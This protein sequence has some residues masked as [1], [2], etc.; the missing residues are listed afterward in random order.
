MAATTGE[1]RNE[2]QKNEPKDRCFLSAARPI[3]HEMR[4]QIIKKRRIPPRIKRLA[5]A[6]EAVESH[7]ILEGVL[8][9][10]YSRCLTASLFHGKNASIPIAAKMTM[11]T[12]AA[13]R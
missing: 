5:V 9:R 13:A 2:I 6:C 12:S 10:T 7:V 3:S 4:I 1:T 8:H 11:E